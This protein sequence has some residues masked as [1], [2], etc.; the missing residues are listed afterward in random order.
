VKL[1]G[2]YVPGITAPGRDRAFVAGMVEIA[3]AVGAEV[4]GERIE[5]EAEATVLAG[6]G[7]GYGQGWLF[8]RPEDL[9][10]LH[11]TVGIRAGEKESWG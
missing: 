2:S 3:R 1:D 10:A 7:V 4:V 5:T 6:L 11:R 8:G 9:P